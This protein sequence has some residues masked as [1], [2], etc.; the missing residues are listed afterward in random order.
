MQLYHQFQDKRL[1]MRC[2]L[3]VL[4][5]ICW[6]LSLNLI[7]N[8]KKQY[9][10]FLN[11]ESDTPYFGNNIINFKYLPSP[12]QDELFRQIKS[13]CLKFT[14]FIITSKEFSDY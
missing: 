9:H 12:V 4:G 3:P 13:D 6:N 5:E 7:N 11:H 1:S 2:F 14:K 10:F 8:I